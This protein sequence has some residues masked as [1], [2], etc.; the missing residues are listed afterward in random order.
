[1]E[2]SYTY[3]G[4][5]INYSTLGGT[6]EITSFGYPL[7]RFIGLGEIKG[8]KEAETYIDKISEMSD[9]ERITFFGQ[10]IMN[11]SPLGDYYDIAGY[12]PDTHFNY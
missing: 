8:R 9:S 3:K 12:K 1:M 6:T 5:T 7:K 10:E 2:T 11:E 4:Y